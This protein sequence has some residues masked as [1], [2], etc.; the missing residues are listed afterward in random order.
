ME[1]QTNVALMHRCI[2]TSC[3]DVQMHLYT[4]ALMHQGNYELMKS[5]FE[6]LKLCNRM[7]APASMQPYCEHIVNR[8]GFKIIEMDKHGL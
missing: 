4:Y 3:I 5:F 6:R 8:E 1:A 7:K 2:Y